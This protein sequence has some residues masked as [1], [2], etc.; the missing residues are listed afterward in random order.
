MTNN[1]KMASKINVKVNKSIN[2]N[3]ATQNI[4]YFKSLP[5]VESE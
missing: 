4:V 1:T 2:N 5:N 3:Y